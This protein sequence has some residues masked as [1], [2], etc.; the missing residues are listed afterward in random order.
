MRESE[1]K[2]ETRATPAGQKVSKPANPAFAFHMFSDSPTEDVDLPDRRGGVENTES[3]DAEGYYKVSPGEHFDNGK[4]IAI[5]AVGQGVFSS[6]FKCKKVSDGAEVA[7]KMIRNND[8]MLRAGLKEIEILRTIMEEDPD[9]KRHCVRMLDHFN[10]KGQHL[11]LV[12]ECLELNLREVLK[13]FGGNQGISLQGVRVYARQILHALHLLGR[14]KIVHADL[15]PDNILVNK[16]K[17]SVKVCDFGSAAKIEE[18][19]PTPYLVSRFY[20]A[21]EVVLGLSYG[22]PVDMWSLGCILFE[23]YT[24]KIAFPGRN[25]NEM[26]RLFQE[27]CGQVPNRILKKALFRDDHYDE[28]FN[29]LQQETDP[30]TKLSIVRPVAVPVHPRAILKEGIMAA[31]DPQEKRAA[32]LLSDLVE[33]MFSLDA[34]KRISVSAA[35]RHPFF[36]S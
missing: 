34:S 5:N 15:K 20:R 4:Y 26:L 16:E 2:E 17:T 11:C 7:L 9:D 31:A 28:A 13:K 27:A 32:G 18:C 19:D 23:L 3:T 24:G 36:T 33:K 12:F 22:T 25:N 10:H 14:L 29:F 1:Q 35:L 8:V 30:V 21:P 6:V